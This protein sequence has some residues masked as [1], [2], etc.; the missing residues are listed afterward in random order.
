MKRTDILWKSEQYQS[1]EN[2]VIKEIDGS[3]TVDS[4]ISGLADKTNFSLEYAININSRWETTS[5]HLK[6]LLPEKKEELEF[7]RHDNYTWNLNGN[8]I[9]ELDNCID[10]DI[11]LT[12]FT[13]TLPIKRLNF[14]ESN[15][16]LIKVLYIDVLEREVKAVNQSYTKLSSTRY[17]FENV[18]NDFEAHIELDQNGFVEHYPGLFERVRN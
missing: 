2:C 5:F 15:R 9:G 13:N 4:S 1:L 3:L 18:P 16:N 17:K 7:I 11:S 12:P 14:D 8:R 6:I 10:I